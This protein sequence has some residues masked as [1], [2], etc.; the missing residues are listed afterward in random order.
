MVADETRTRI[1]EA[2]GP[3]FAE[4]GFRSATVREICRQAGVNVASINYHFGDKERLYI[5]TVKYAH[6][7]RAQQ[8]P[9][10]EFPVGTAPEQKL[11]AFI[12]ALVTRMIGVPRSPWEVQLL[13][14]EVL[15]PTGACKELVESYFRPMFGRLLSIL[16]EL[17][18]AETP[19]FKRKQI[20]FSIVGQCLHYRVAGEVVAMI[21]PEDEHKAHF[22]PSHLA[23]HIADLSLAA[24]G[25][26]PP[27]QSFSEEA[28]PSHT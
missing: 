9:L 20:G 13:L 4:K 12:H 18:P 8:V 26:G 27:V 23:D 28:N 19:D 14:R 17:L 10:P 15:Q 5:E 16:D 21:V 22:E 11:R 3:V 7:Q 1:C 24:L 25:A 2:A 6:E